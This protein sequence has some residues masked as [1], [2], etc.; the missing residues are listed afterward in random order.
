VLFEVELFRDA[1]RGRVAETSALGSCRIVTRPVF[2]SLTT[3]SGLSRAISLAEC[4]E[5][6]AVV[7]RFISVHGDVTY[8]DRIVFPDRIYLQLASGHA[9]AV[10]GET[11]ARLTRS[12]REGGPAGKVRW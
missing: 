10:N 5:I 11:I 2:I 4:R 3:T 1:V 6:D 7:M 8:L 12:R 9:L